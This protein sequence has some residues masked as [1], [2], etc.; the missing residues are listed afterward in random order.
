MNCQTVR[1]PGCSLC[2]QPM[3][4]H[5][6]TWGSSMQDLRDTKAS[7]VVE[8]CLHSLV[9][10]LFNLKQAAFAPA[11]PLRLSSPRWKA[12]PPIPT[13]RPHFPDLGS[14]K[15]KGQQGLLGQYGELGPQAMIQHSRVC[16]SST[17]RSHWGEG[18]KRSKSPK[19]QPPVNP[20]LPMPKSKPSKSC[21]VP[22]HSVI[23]DTKPNETLLE[24]KRSCS[25]YCNCNQV[26]AST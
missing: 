26:L 14:Q 15:E 3:L 6:I 9:L 4:L 21:R 16:A 7:T 18:Q 10:K 20:G 12:A 8:W 25:N 17:A 23:S 22:A 5:V 19:P 13:Q 24:G 2:W 1:L 11:R